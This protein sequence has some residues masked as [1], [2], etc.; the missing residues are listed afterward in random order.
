MDGNEEAEDLNIS[1]LY[2][3]T[4]LCNV[5][6][7]LSLLSAIRPQSGPILRGL[8]DVEQ[9]ERRMSR[10]CRIDTEFEF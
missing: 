5:A 2:K 10:E 4:V 7:C 8:T 3:Y 9:E 1:R 6:H